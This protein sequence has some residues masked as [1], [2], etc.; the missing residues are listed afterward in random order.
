MRFVWWAVVLIGVVLAGAGGYTTYAA[1]S[2]ISY[3]KSCGRSVAVCSTRGNPISILGLSSALRASLQ[4][5]ELVWLLG[6][7]LLGIGLAAI[8]YG[9]YIHP[10]IRKPPA[11]IEENAAGS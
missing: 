6:I 10:S 9:V 11:Q 7:A 4:E 2:A 5:A 3:I 1:Q 8:A